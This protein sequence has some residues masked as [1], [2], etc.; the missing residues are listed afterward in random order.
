MNVN[1]SVWKSDGISSEVRDRKILR[2]R[3]LSIIKE[4]SLHC[5]PRKSAIYYY[6]TQKFYLKD[7]FSLFILHKMVRNDDNAEFSSLNLQP[8]E[9]SISRKSNQ[10]SIHRPTVGNIVASG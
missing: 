7:K 1:V 4:F 6:E 2:K 8:V 3:N 10:L 9:G 5:P